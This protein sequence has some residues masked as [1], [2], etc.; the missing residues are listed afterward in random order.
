MGDGLKRACRSL[1]SAYQDSE[2]MDTALV[3][4]HWRREFLLQLRG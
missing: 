4:L 3:T 1:L 2:F